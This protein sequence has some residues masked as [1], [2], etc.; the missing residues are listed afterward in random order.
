MAQNGFVWRR[1][2]YLV[3]QADGQIRDWP[4][5]DRT[6]HLLASRFRIV[7]I[8]SMDPGGDRG[9]LRVLNNRLFRGALRTLGA[10]PVWRS[11]CER[12]R[13][14]REPTIEARRL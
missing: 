9:I 14:G 5:L 6:K 3:P 11:I 8:G 12:L 10:G 7:H 13:L 1:S 2:S 4:P